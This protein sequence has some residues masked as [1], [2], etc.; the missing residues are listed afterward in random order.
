MVKRKK[1]KKKKKKTKAKKEK[2]KAILSLA[3]KQKIKALVMF[4]VG[5]IFILSLLELAGPAGE[6]IDRG[7]VFLIG[8]A[9]FAVPL[10]FII[11]GLIFLKPKQKGKLFPLILGIFILI[12][13]M[14][15]ILGAFD[16]MERQAVNE[17]VWNWAGKGGFLGNLLSW[18]LLHYFGVFVTNIIF[19]AVI[20]GGLLIFFQFIEKEIVEKEKPSEITQK[21]KRAITPAARRIKEAASSRKKIKE[22]EPKIS[23]FREKIDLSNNTSSKKGKYVLPPLELLK[24]EKG[25]P[26]SGD[27]K[28]NSKIIKKTLENFGIAVEMA[29]VNIGPTVTQ[30]S[31]RPAEG[32]KLSRITTL[33]R[34]LSLA[35][36]A[37]PL[38]I[39]APIPGKDLVGIE[40]PNSQRSQVRLR[41]LIANPTFQ[42]SSS[43]LLFCL[44]RS[45]SGDPMYADLGKMPHLLVAGST[46]SGKTVFLNN[47]VLSFLYRNSPRRLNFI[48]VD[49]K[50]VEFQS[51]NHFPHLLTPVITNVDIAINALN[52]LVQEME[53]R[54]EVFSTIPTRNI[55]TYNSMKSVK[56]SGAQLPYIVL[57]VDELADFMAS[58]GREM[59]AAIVRLAQMAR[60]TGIHLIVATQRPSVEVITGLIK[61]NITARVTFQVASQVDSR[62]VLDMAGAE[63]LLG[64]GDMLYISSQMTKPK[65]IQGAYVSEKEVKKVTQFI[66]KEK[67]KARPP[68]DL[69]QSLKNHLEKEKQKP[70]SFEV[71]EDELYEDAK[72]LVIDAGKGSASLLQRRLRIGYARAAR[73]L[74]ML[75]EKGIVGPARGSKPRKVLAEEEYDEEDDFG[76]E[77]ES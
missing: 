76:D 1:S 41:N 21:I 33:S 58:K 27:I 2:K 28:K 53:R 36:A 38:R 73:L 68:S 59:E 31:F 32:I 57:I 46:G 12:L 11:T 54:F 20:I 47:L 16:T 74:D 51:Y 45:V 30:Y 63:S 19:G 70:Q 66:K 64:D 39:E 49:P 56:E 26:T 75:Q 50:R 14:T 48:L 67:D 18:P 10:L 29:E 71:G 4:V 40:I 13:G 69:S 52:W 55:S 43:S 25:N 35:L 34:N 24:E 3:T 6:A 5:I 8:K 9:V 77:L 60:A 15:G 61:A 72:E 7:F 23:R 37:H 22:T 65:R 42:N 62:T 44:G 17:F